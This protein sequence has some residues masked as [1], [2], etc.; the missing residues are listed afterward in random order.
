[1]LLPS[2]LLRSV[3]VPS[4]DS[5]A[6]R[7][8]VG[9]THVLQMTIADPGREKADAVWTYFTPVNEVSALSNISCW[10]FQKSVLAMQALY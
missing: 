1:M 6:L 7:A 10:Y 8:A 9:E 4:H 5:A 2:T 3:V